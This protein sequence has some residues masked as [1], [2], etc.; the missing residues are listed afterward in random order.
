MKFLDSNV[1]AYAFYTNEYTDACQNALREGGI[2]DVFNLVEAFFIIERETGSREIAQR[3]IK[4]LLKS[5]IQ[6]IDVDVNLLFEALKRVNNLKLSIFDAIHY[7]CATVSNC[8]AIVS[9]DKDFDKLDMPR[10]EP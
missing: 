2:V 3:S 1:I 10:E 7:S 6:I 8:D 4:N 5:N 9:Y